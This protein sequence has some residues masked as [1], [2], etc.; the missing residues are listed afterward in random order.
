MKLELRRNK[1]VRKGEM[2]MA[3]LLKREWTAEEVEKIEIEE[4]QP[5][6]TR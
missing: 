6:A 5:L 3:K 2:N 4:F 1:R